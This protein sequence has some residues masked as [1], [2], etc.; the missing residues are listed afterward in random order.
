[1]IRSVLAVLAGYLITALLVMVSTMLAM[2]FV[3]RQPRV[4]AGR[5]PVG[6]RAGS[7]LATNLAASGLASCVGGFVTGVLAVGR[8]L[9]PGL[10]L[11]AVMV[12]LSLVS[13]R[14]A[15]NAQPRWYQ[16][17]LVTI[18]PPLAVAGSLVSGMH[19][20]RP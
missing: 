5:G 8:P 3:L 17:V 20:V 12:L 18:M 10:G 15:Q 4:A 9:G 11:A 7:Y 14:Q 16:I 19:G 13:M 2:R 1:M 6:P